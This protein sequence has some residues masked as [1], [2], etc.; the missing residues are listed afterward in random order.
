[1]RKQLTA[2]ILGFSLALSGASGWAADEP[3]A[4]STALLNE[5]RLLRQAIERQSA[6]A[7]RAQLLVGR[8]GV[9][10]Q[11]VARW[12][13]DVQR[14]EAETA[15][16]GAEVPRLQMALSRMRM[17]LEQAKDAEQ[18]SGAEHEVLAIEEQIKERRASLHVLETRR[19]EAKRILDTERAR[20]D[21]LNERLDQME[22]ETTRP[23][24]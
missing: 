2:A 8:L 9:Q 15:G 14:L 1:M 24:R 10:D 20:Y 16:L 5:V 19:D 6:L 13:A 11:R 12:Q 21:E 7:G 18:T 17:N 22:R 3:S 4:G 23:A